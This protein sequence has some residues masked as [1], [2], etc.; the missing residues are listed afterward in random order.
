MRFFIIILLSF[1]FIFGT[2]RKESL[3]NIGMTNVK[4]LDSLPDILKTPLIATAFVPD[5]GDTVINP[6]GEP[7]GNLTNKFI[8]LGK[9]VF[10][11][12]DRYY[13]VYNDVETIVIFTPYHIFIIQNIPTDV[14]HIIVKDQPSVPA[15]FLFQMILLGQGKTANLYIK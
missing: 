12:T 3:E 5:D 10:P 2:T 13:G 11:I 8:Q 9:E 1:S 15:R 7:Y 4:Q 6:D 14:R